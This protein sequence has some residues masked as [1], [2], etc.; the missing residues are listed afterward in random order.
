M[1]V[2]L[3]IAD[4]ADDD[5]RNAWPGMARLA[6]KARVS[7]RAVQRAVVGLV[8]LGELEV[9]RQAG[10]PPAL[11]ADRRPNLFRVLMHGVTLETPREPDGVTLVA[12][13]GDTGGGDG[14]TP[15]SPETSNAPV[16]EDLVRSGTR[17]KNGSG[18]RVPLDWTGLESVR[19]ALDRL[20][21]A[22]TEGFPL[23]SLRDPGYWRTIDALTE[24]TEVYYLDELRLYLAWW[25]TRPLSSRH[26]N[27]RRG[28]QA[29][30]RRELGR[31]K[32]RAARR[33]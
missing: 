19:V 21:G 29:W 3:A 24:G 26:R 12:V 14:V 9:Q 11:R 16:L 18:S 20:N 2:L 25:P 17:P 28:F 7:E 22:A 5:G 23:E 8:G 13:R 33:G 15:A 10:G 31:E 32:W 27:V 6:T 30:I 1:V 4:Q